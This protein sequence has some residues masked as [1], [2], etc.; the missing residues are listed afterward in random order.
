MSVHLRQAVYYGIG[1]D[2]SF[3]AS[4]HYFTVYVDDLDKNRAAGERF[5]GWQ[6]CASVNEL[7]EIL[8]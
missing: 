1:K 2:N 7:K 5:P 4:L 8:S 3:D 6:T